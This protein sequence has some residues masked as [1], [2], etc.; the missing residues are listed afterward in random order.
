MAG[1]YRLA[2][3]AGGAPH[4]A[5][6]SQGS[7]SH[8]AGARPCPL[9]ASAD[10]AEGGGRRGPLSRHC[11]PQ[12]RRPSAGR[13]RRVRRAAV[14]R[15]RDQDLLPEEGHAPDEVC[16]PPRPQARAGSS[17]PLPRRGVVQPPVVVAGWFP[18]RSCRSGRSCG[19]RQS[20]GS[21]ARS[22]SA[23]ATTDRFWSWVP[24][25][26]RHRMVASSLSWWPL[27]S[28]A[29]SA[30]ARTSSRG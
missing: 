18:T 28:R 29:L 20:R 16:P 24:C 26:S 11:R 4:S 14:R 7:S 12:D 22:G 23:P 8:R 30:S 5:G 21:L 15:P 13:T 9:R 2:T 25:Q 17:A 6:G 1:D 19:C 10:A 27:A 3:S